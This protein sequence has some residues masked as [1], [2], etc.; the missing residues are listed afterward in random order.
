MASICNPAIFQTSSLKPTF[1]LDVCK[2]QTK[3]ACNA[4]TSPHY[5]HFIFSAMSVA[6]NGDGNFQSSCYDRVIQES[7]G[8]R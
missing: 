5:A 6:Q 1:K 8:S 3:P 4:P 2:S 7:E